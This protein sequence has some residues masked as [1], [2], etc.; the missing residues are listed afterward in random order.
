ML[1]LLIIPLLF[2]ATIG[3]SQKQ[4]TWKTLEDVRFTDKY[5]EKEEAYY[6]YPH[7]G[8]SVKALHGK[9]VFIKGYMLTIKPKDGIYVLS[10]NPYAACF[11]CGNG[12]PESIVELKL[13][14]GHPRFRM[15][16]VVTIRGRL[17][18][19]RDDLYQCN[20][21]LELAEVYDP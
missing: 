9:E 7:F 11:F 2:T 1:R 18:L 17:K 5:S 10:R 13:K 6:Y 8:S 16:Q 19:N 14:P 4:I 15:D 12:G 21:I 20:Y 3:I